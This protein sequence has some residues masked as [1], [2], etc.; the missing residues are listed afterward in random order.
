MP[1]SPLRRKTAFT[2]QTERRPVKV[3]SPRWLAPLMVACFLVGLVWIVVYYVS[4]TE[5]PIK[6]IGAGNM[7]I[8]FGFIVAGFGLSTQWK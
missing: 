7:A 6:A 4:Q 3:G 1:K 2:R 5:Y 8:G